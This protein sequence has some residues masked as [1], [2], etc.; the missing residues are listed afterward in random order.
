MSAL[1]ARAAPGGARG[2]GVMR[3]ASLRKFLKDRQPAALCGSR[4][5]KQFRML[6][7]GVPAG[8]PLRGIT[9]LMER[10]L[11]CTTAA[12]PHAATHGF[13]PARWA[14]TSGRARGAR[15]DRQLTRVVNGERGA[16]PSYLLTQ[17]VLGF[18]A[19]QG[20]RPVFCQRVV[21]APEAR[22]ATAIDLLAYDAAEDALWV[23]ELK[24]GY[25]GDREAAAQRGGRPCTMQPPLGSAT[26]NLFNRHMLQAVLGREMLVREPGFLAGLSGGFGVADVRAGVIYADGNAVQLVVPAQWWAARAG[27]ALRALR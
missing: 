1:G 10:R 20:L 15:V 16:R 19:E 26:D 14:K 24:C 11:F 6:R 22:L 27:R 4:N 7:L 17:L 12:L 21:A 13:D 18:L 5:T 8:P 25:S 2:S 23:L 9:K 3:I